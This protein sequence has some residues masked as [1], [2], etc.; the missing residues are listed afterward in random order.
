MKHLKQI[1]ES[2]YTS[3]LWNFLSQEQIESLASD[4]PQTIYSV[5]VRNYD[6][7]KQKKF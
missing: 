4:N 1:K 5:T 3:K 2:T 7:A 6:S